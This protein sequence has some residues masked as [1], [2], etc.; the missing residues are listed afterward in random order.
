MN[1]DG[2]G[3]VLRFTS[4]S[5]P[6]V[7]L[8]VVGGSSHASQHDLEQIFSL[9]DSPRRDLEVLWPGG[10]RTSLDDIP[11]GGRV[12]LPDISSPD[13]RDAVLEAHGLADIGGDRL[14]ACR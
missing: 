12:T 11:A 1:R 13:A 2:I 9:G 4:A 8:P 3:A 10:G 7:L 6:A 14:M 5:K